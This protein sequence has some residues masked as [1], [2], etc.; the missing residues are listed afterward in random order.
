MKYLKLKKFKIK[1]LRKIKRPIKMIIKR[2]KK[3]FIKIFLKKKKTKLM[4]KK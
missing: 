4:I 2:L 3:S 1:K